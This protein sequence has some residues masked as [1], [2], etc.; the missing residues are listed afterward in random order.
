[1]GGSLS[2][3]LPFLSRITRS[4]CHHE[5]CFVSEQL[6]QPCVEFS[7]ATG[8]CS[9]AD[10]GNGAALISSDVARENPRLTADVLQVIPTSKSSSQ[11]RFDLQSSMSFQFI[12]ARIRTSIDRAVSES[13]IA[14]RTGVSS[15]LR[16]HTRDAPATDINP[17]FSH[18]AETSFPT[19]RV[20]PL[21]LRGRS[22]G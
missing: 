11:P 14:A 5:R 15:D 20:S 16:N 18:Q 6:Q 8:K 7:P 13:A 1:M 12:K 2:T 21:A 9:G 17:L 4:S 10:L 19:A 22:K 3:S